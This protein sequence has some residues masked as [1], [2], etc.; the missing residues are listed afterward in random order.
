MKLIDVTKFLS[1]KASHQSLGRVFGVNSVKTELDFLE[2]RHEQQKFMNREPLGYAIDSRTIR[3]GDL[4]FAIKGENHDGHHFVADVLS[5]GAIA[6]V[7]NRE[8]A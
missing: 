4:F 1:S 2:F 6:A 5:K 3:E 8:S 7:I